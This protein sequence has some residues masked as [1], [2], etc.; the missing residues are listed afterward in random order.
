[1]AKKAK[2]MVI[3]KANDIESSDE[4]TELLRKQKNLR[5]NQLKKHK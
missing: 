1:M 3:Q 5:M 2:T 4:M